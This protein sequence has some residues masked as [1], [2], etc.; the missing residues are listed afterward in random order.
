MVAGGGSFGC[1]E[2][3]GGRVGVPK[4]LRLVMFSS[5]D[6]PKTPTKEGLDILL[7]GEEGSPQWFTRA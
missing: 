3:G 2:A 4:R 6:S 1:V 7:S 5:D